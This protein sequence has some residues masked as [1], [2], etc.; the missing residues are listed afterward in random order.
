MFKSEATEEQTDKQNEIA[1]NEEICTYCKMHKI[2]NQMCTV[3][4]TLN[5]E[6]EQ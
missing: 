6:L 5:E 3:G 4:G 2:K 1:S